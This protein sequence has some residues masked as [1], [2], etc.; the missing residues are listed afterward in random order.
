MEAMKLIGLRKFALKILF[1]LFIPIVLPANLLEVYSVISC[2]SRPDNSY[3]INKFIKDYGNP[4]RNAEGAL[5]FKGKGEMYGS[6][7]REFFVSSTKGLSFVGVV[8]ENSP[9]FVVDKIVSAPLFP[10]N[11]M[12]NGDYWVGSDGRSI[13]WHQGYYTKIFCSVSASPQ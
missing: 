7:I 12:V 8:L 11:V 6:P 9:P 2:N 13:M 1:V 4:I 3:F 10:T 5:W